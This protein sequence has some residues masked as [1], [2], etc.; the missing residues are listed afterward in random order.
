MEIFGKNRA[1][2]GIR[3]A[4]KQHL[5]GRLRQAVP[6]L[7]IHGRVTAI[8]GK[9]WP[10]EKPSHDFPE[11]DPGAKKLCGSVGC[12][13][14]PTG[15]KQKQIRGRHGKTRFLPVIS[16]EI[17][18]GVIRFRDRFVGGQCFAPTGHVIERRAD[19]K[20]RLL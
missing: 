14:Q 15:T 13:R 12:G 4:E 19:G 8:S 20:L 1:Y 9:R 10:A 17:P 18:V 6:S 16:H 3:R 7:G 11:I 2:L 5:V